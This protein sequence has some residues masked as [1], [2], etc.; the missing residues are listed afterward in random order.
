VSGIEATPP[1]V[2]RPPISGGLFVGQIHSSQSML[3]CKRQN[4]AMQT[5]ALLLASG[6][7]RFSLDHDAAIRCTLEKGTTMSKTASIVNGPSTTT[8]FGRLMASIDKLLMV[9]AR[10]AQRNGELPYFGL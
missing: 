4:A 3:H 9:S 6:I 5:N 7:R 2:Q 8:L 1:N 10:A